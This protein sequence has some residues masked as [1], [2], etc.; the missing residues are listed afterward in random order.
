MVN[1]KKS[2]PKHYVLYNLDITI[3]S[4][5][6]FTTLRYHHCHHYLFTASWCWTKM[7]TTTLN[8]IWFIITSKASQHILDL[9]SSFISKSLKAWRCKF[10]LL[11]FFHYRCLC[12][13][14]LKLHLKY[15]GKLWV[16]VIRVFW[17]SEVWLCRYDCTRTTHP[18]VW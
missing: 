15:A 18:E 10:A 11:H 4:K 9:C 5:H 13:Q 6:I 16:V 14:T 1:I 2:R 8:F 7:H 3:V 17:L 12:S